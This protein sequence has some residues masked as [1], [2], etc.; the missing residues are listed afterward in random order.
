ML[1]RVSISVLPTLLSEDLAE[2]S[3][4]DTIVFDETLVLDESIR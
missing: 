2:I 1:V 3:E 4:L